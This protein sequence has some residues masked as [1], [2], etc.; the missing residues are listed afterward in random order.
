MAH[1]VEGMSKTKVK[2]GLYLLGFYPNGEMH[3]PLL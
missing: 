2:T 3:T 1:E